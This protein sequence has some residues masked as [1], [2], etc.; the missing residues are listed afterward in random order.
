[1]QSSQADT[2]SCSE[3][4]VITNDAVSFRSLSNRYVDN[5]CVLAAAATDLEAV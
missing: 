4:S 1:L 3:F 5:Y 2:T